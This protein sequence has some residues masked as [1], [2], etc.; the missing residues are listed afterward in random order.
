ME[1]LFR[2]Y[3]IVMI[4]MLGCNSSVEWRDNPPKEFIGKFYEISTAVIQ[5]QQKPSIIVISNSH[6]SIHHLENDFESARQIRAV[7]I[8]H[9]G[10]VIFCGEKNQEHIADHRYKI[11]WT[12][13]GY[14]VIEEILNP[15]GEDLLVD[16]GTFTKNNYM[17]TLN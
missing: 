11:S 7:S 8:A 15:Y 9:N 6:F 4:F 2:T 13:D 16:F 12:S 14:L 5:G 3:F 1:G 10:I 17:E